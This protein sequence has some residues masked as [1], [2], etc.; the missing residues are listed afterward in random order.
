MISK[1]ILKPKGPFSLKKIAT[2]LKD[3]IVGD[4]NIILKDVASIEKANKCNIT[5][6]DNKKYLKKLNFTKAS[7][8]IISKEVFQKYSNNAKLNFLISN[9]PYLSYAKIN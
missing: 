8:C 4:P 5:F 9:N 7:V 1:I 2:I 6:I 3:E